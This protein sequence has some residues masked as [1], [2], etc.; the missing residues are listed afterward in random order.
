[1]RVGLGGI[2]GTN[3]LSIGRGVSVGGGGGGAPSLDP[4]AITLIAAMTTEPD[5]ARQALIS[6]TIVALKNAGIWS[7]L[8]ECWFLAAH[9]AQAALLGW[10][11]YRDCTAVN[12]PTFEVDRGFAGDGATSYLDT[13][14][15]PSTDGVNYTLNGASLGAY[16]RTDIATDNTAD[17]GARTS[18]DDTFINSRNSG[19][20]FNARIHSVSSI[21]IATSDS[22]GLHS[23]QR[24]D[25]NAAQL[26]RNGV[27]V[28]S[29]TVNAPALP[30]VSFYICALHQSDGPSHFTQRQNAF[31][32]VAAAMSEQQQADLYNIVQ[33]YMTAIGAAV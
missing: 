32:F 24:T 5:A 17:I 14:F 7:L 26:F 25:V 22:F 9:D 1:M 16:I 18:G 30:T 31:A 10:K 21:N 33:S 12:A 6:N 8:D 19:G 4:D 20:N 3:I 29:A 28:T 15:V 27:Q 13:G 23:A 2:S 11:R